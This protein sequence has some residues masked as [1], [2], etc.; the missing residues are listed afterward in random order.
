MQMICDI[1][2]LCGKWNFM[3]I[4]Q[5]DK[6]HKPKAI[7]ELLTFHVNQSDSCSHLNGTIYLQMLDQITYKMIP[8]KIILLFSFIQDHFLVQL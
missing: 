1:P 3:P 5:T 4:T 6:H 8:F 7:P 2:V